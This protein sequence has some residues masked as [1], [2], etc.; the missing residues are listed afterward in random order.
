MAFQNGRH[1]IS[2]RSPHPTILFYLI[3]IMTTFIAPKTC[4]FPT[5]SLEEEQSYWNAWSQRS[6]L[7]PIQPFITSYTTLA[8][9]KFDQ[10]IKQVGNGELQALFIRVNL[11]SGLADIH[12]LLWTSPKEYI[13]IKGSLLSE[14]GYDK[15]RFKDQNLMDQLVMLS[16]EGDIHEVDSNTL[17]ADT[18]YLAIRTTGRTARYVSYSPEIPTT[19]E[20][21]DISSFVNYIQEIIERNHSP[22]KKKRRSRKYRN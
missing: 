4:A 15:M 7:S 9:R 3:F 14:T 20:P 5:L 18:L 17:D 22:K 10:L 1:T 8:A 13:S 11:D 2:L 16:E 21:P 6:S 12:Y 19:L